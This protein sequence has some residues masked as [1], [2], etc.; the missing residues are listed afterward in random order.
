[1]G[2]FYSNV[3]IMAAAIEQAGSTDPAAVRDAVYG[4]SFPGTVIGDVVYSEK[5]TSPVIPLGLQWMGG[6]RLVIFPDV[7]TKMEW[8]K[9]WDQR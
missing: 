9:A 4:G 5:G 3:Q 6:K 2:L 7:G 1:M 8:F